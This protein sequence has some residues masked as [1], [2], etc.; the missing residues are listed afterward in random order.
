MIYFD[1]AAT[2]FP[3]PQCVYDAINEGMRR[4]SFNAGRGGYNLSV[5]T[6][7]MIEDTRQLISDN[8]QSSKESVIFTAS[9]TESLNLIIGGL[10]L[11]NNDYVFVSPFEHNA[12]MRTLYL[13]KVKIEVIPF[14]KTSWRVDLKKLN[15]MF[16]LK[17]P[18]AVLLS[19]VSN[20]TGFILP[21]E[22]IFRLSKH[23]G[24]INIL[25]AAQS[26]GLYESKKEYTDYLVF[27]GHKS[28]YAMFGIAGYINYNMENLKMMK[29][30]GTGSDSLNL[31]MPLN[32][33]QRYEPGSLNSVGIYSINTSLKFLRSENFAEREFDLMVYLLSRLKDC[34][35]I[36]TFIPEGYIPYGIISIAVEG[37][38]SDDIGVILAED[39]DICVRTGYHCAPLVHD[40]IESKAYNGTVRISLGGFNNKEE[41]D[42]LV[43]ALKEIAT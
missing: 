7:K 35:A 24:A 43:Q 37:F 20:V 29:G 5:E 16:I 31:E 6:Y 8:A 12:I 9:A 40:F 13:Y 11:T 19:Q 39:Y 14:D 26:F 10:N 17:R 38:S 34:K 3:K 21:Y 22:D 1:N 42:L 23:F 41:I 33:T 28:L 36:K 4:Y 32:F 2:T 18:K 27:A 15:D 30:G 25:D